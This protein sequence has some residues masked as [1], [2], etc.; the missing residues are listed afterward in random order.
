MNSSQL[1][2]F[3]EKVKCTLLPYLY[4]VLEKGVPF[5]SRTASRRLSL[6]LENFYV[7]GI[8]SAVELVKN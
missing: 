4:K 3:N 1:S 7:N 8:A 2:Y 6:Q 5:Q